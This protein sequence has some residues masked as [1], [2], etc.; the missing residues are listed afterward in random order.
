MTKILRGMVTALAGALFLLAATAEAAPPPPPGSLRQ[1]PLGP[2]EQRQIQLGRL[3][4]TP[5]I[6]PTG[7]GTTHGSIDATSPLTERSWKEAGSPHV[8]QY[9]VNISVPVTIESCAVV[10]IGVN[11]T[12]TIGA[13]GAFTA[14]GQRERPVIIEPRFAGMA[15][16]QIRVLGGTLSLTKTIVRGGGAGT[17]TAYLGA[18]RLQSGSLLVDDVEIADSRSQGVYIN[19]N[20]IGFDAASQNLRVHGS[21]GFPVNVCA[22]AIGSVPSGQYTGNGRDAI[23]IGISGSCGSVVNNQTIHNRGVPY[24][25]GLGADSGRLDID[26]KTSGATAV[27]VIEPGVNVLFP[28]GGMLNV[29]GRN[30]TN[31]P[32]LG[33]LIAN[34][35]GAPII[36]TS[37]QG[38]ASAPGNWLGIR[39]GDPVAP[40]NVLNNVKV[41]FA[42]GADVTG[43]AS[44]PY[45]AANNPVA[46]DVAHDAAIRI[47]GE[48][49]GQFITNTEIVASARFGIDRGWHGNSLTD[50]LSSVP[51][52]TFTAVAL[53]KQTLPSPAIG[54]CPASPPCP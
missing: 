18:L 5:C 46:L 43:S 2:T 22:N 25:I 17:P 20:M 21:V 11:K 45:H 26:S 6:A 35:N 1:P 42:G 31:G 34:S 10:R 23:G 32:A 16:S 27:L 49:P 29:A 54:S 48:P 52:N 38:T 8:L 53:C 13:G 15:W 44:C 51:L 30:V 47:Y 12:I 33:A 7:V 40:N 39:F 37:D 3:G 4:I 41:M 9:D 19:N 28:P 36:F 50:F 14:M 24:H